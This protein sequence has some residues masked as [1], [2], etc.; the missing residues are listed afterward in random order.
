[1]VRPTTIPKAKTSTQRKQYPAIRNTIWRV[2]RVN[3]YPRLSVGIFQHVAAEAIFSAGH[4]QRL[5]VG[6]FALQAHEFAVAML[7]AKH[8]PGLELV[9]LA[10]QVRKVAKHGQVREV[11]LQLAEQAIHGVIAPDHHV[12]GGEAKAG[13]LGRSGRLRRRRFRYARGGGL[14]RHFAVAWPQRQ[15]G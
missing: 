3:E 12:D 2:S 4:L 11:Q 9:D 5:A 15:R 8:F 14:L 13:F 7:E 1:M 6:K 10:A